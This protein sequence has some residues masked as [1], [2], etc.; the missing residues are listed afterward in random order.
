[1][2]LVREIYTVTRNFPREEQ[3]GLTSQLRRAA[4]SIPANIAEGYGRG[5]KPLFAQFACVSRGSLYETRTL[6]EI[7]VMTH[8]ATENEIAPLLEQ[9]VKLSRM[10]EGFIRSL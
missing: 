8:V 2:D 5:T 7:A 3:F 10:L 4:V 9:A 6:L 1:M